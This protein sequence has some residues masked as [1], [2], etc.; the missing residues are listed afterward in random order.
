MSVLWQ[1]GYLS[2][3]C[4]E[5]LELHMLAETHEPVSWFQR[6]RYNAPSMGLQK[7][8]AEASPQPSLA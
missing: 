8:L 1:H 5:K 4:L 3:L 6:G 7:S 2:L